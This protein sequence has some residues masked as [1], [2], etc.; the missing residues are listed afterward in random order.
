MWKLSSNS[1]GVRIVRWVMLYPL[2]LSS[3]LGN[4]SRR[5]VHRAKIFG[6]KASLNNIHQVEVA[7]GVNTQTLPPLTNHATIRTKVKR[8]VSNKW[9]SRQT[10]WCCKSKMNFEIIV[11]IAFRKLHTE[12]HQFFFISSNTKYSTPFS[13]K[14]TSSNNYISRSSFYVFILPTSI[15]NYG[16]SRSTRLYKSKRNTTNP[17]LFSVSIINS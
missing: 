1:L 15:P 8:S 3:D 12:T 6:Q 4:R 14:W 10:E 9:N 11:Q 7:G 17:S 2:S 13:S 5:M 16:L